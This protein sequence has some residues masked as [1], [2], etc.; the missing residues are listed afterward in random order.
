[1]KLLQLHSR[2]NVSYRG[3]RLNVPHEVNY[4]AVDPD[5]QLV[6]FES[7][8]VDGKDWWDAP[9]ADHI[10]YLGVV[11]LDGTFW[12]TTCERVGRHYDY[13]VYRSK[14]DVVA[15]GLPSGTMVIVGYPG[16]GSIHRVND[17][18]SPKFLW[19]F[20]KS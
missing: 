11:D 6:G 2:K 5:G 8:P 3:M 1:M 4:I 9:K 15:A 12:R 18:G 10:E 16:I 20:S 17:D 19:H 7:E 14:E 13:P